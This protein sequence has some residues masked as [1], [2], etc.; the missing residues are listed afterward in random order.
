MLSSLRSGYH[1]RLCSAEKKLYDATCMQ[2]GPN[3]NVVSGFCEKEPPTLNGAG[4]NF[5]RLQLVSLDWQILEPS[6][7]KDE[8]AVSH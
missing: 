3:K 8:R 1:P 5:F 6:L 4:S 2:P 7:A